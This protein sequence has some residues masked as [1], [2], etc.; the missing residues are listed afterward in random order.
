MNARQKT[1][2]IIILGSI[3]SLGPFSIDMYLPGFPA[4]A[5]DLQTTEARVALTLTSYFIGIATGQLVYGPLV[6]RYGRKMPLLIGLAIYSVA[7]L[8][9]A[10]APEVNALIGLRLLQALG[11]CVGIVA[12]NAIVRDIFPVEEVARV[13]SSMLL[14]MGVAPIIAPTLGGYFI[15]HL[16]WRSIFVFLSAI[17]LLLIGVIY[18]YLKESRAADTSVSLR[19]TQIA[20]NYWKVLKNQDFLL[21]GLAG[22]IAMA[23]IFA[24]ISG[25]SFVLINLYEVTET[26]FGWLFGLNAFGFILG[27]QINRFL[28][29]RM[30]LLKVTTVASGLQVGVTL[31]LFLGTLLLDLPL[32]PFLALV[33]S[34]LF[35][36]GFI[37]PNSSALSLAPFTKN[38]GVASA[39]NGSLRMGTGALASALMGLFYNGTAI[40]MVSIM[41][42]FSVVAFLL[43]LR[44]RKLDDIQQE[45]GKLQKQAA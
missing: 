4:I 11:G 14:V 31:S 37:N 21:Y 5:E 23:V 16:G 15:A 19:P 26:T 10:M 40:P 41:V 44:G 20:R 34:A 7:S 1:G 42:S 36:L 12:A 13:F 32:V 22:S 38:A 29:H 45:E 9:C 39:L 2:L 17:S 33:F 8:G 30:R 24:Y 3:A 35:L 25:I 27:S 18:F 28:L 6:D 43:I